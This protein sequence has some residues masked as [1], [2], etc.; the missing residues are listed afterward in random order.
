MAGPTIMQIVPRLRVGGA[1]RLASDVAIAVARAGGRSIVVSEGG[2]MVPALEEAGCEFYPLSVGSKNPGRI[3]ANGYKLAKAVVRENVAL[4]NVHSRA[5]AWSA[6]LAA[7]RTGIPLVNSYHSVYGLGGP[8]KSLYNS[9]M[10]RGDVVI[11]NSEFT[12]QLIRERHPWASDRI[13]YVPAGIDLELFDPD[14]VSPSE[15]AALRSA[16]QSG[17]QVPVLLLPGRLAPR[18]G[19]ETAIEAMRRLAQ[20]SG[21]DSVLVFLGGERGESAYAERVEQQIA[22]AG[23]SD[24]VRFAGLSENMPAAY[25]AADLVVIPSRRAETFGLVA[26]EAQA[27]G[28]PAIVSEIGALPEVV[29]SQTGNSEGITG[30]L[31]PPSDPDALAEAI[32]AALRLPVEERREIGKRAR[33]RVINLFSLATMQRQTLAV[34]DRLLGTRMADGFRH[35]MGEH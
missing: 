27:M 21:P 26:A 3:I 2:P 35:K 28:I 18:K 5:P 29:Q 7:R 19:Q 14:A 9:A 25:L 12:A 31:V 20:S 23:L 30:W 24:R 34:Y 16:W 33:L 15:V 6:L 17:S 8:L 1:E 32:G 10:A 11:A 13:A 4:L 22:A